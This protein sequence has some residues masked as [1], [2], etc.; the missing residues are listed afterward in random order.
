MNESTHRLA[1]RLAAELADRFKP[2]RYAGRAVA[3]LEQA[4]AATDRFQDLELVDVS[5]GRDDPHTPEWNRVNDRP[6]YATNG[7]NHTAFNHFIDIKKGPGQFDDYDGYG[8]FRGSAHVEEYQGAEEDIGGWAHLA[9][10]LTGTKVDQGL[11]YWLNDEYVHAPGQPWYRR[12]SPA[13]ARYSFPRDLG[14]YPSKRAELAERFP[15]ASAI[16]GYG[17]GVPYSVF[18]PVDNLARYWF[19][20]AV[21]ACTPNTMWRCLGPVLH[22]VQDASIPHHAAGYNGNWHQHYE[23]A[24]ETFVQKEG[25]WAACRRQA[26]SLL[27]AWLKRRARPPKRLGLRDARLKPALNWPV[28]HLVTWVALHAYRAYALVYGHF[29]QGF[30]P[31]PASMRRLFALAAAM[32]GLVL[33]KAPSLTPIRNTAST[34]KR[35]ESLRK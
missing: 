28:Q 31:N 2:G 15:L 9:A 3:A 14:V 10:E 32:G 33:L 19:Q 25:E 16:G 12:C 26:A 34:R 7:F 11:N 20:R 18:M 23:Q 27:R 13:L 29:R 8:Y 22:A 6:H 1:T 35:S 5:F 4:A 30:R 21:D 24:L 17:R